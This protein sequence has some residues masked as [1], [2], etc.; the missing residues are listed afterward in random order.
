M[1][2]GRDAK[3]GGG[4]EPCG[5]VMGT[6]TRSQLS[7]LHALYWTR[8]KRLGRGI[9]VARRRSQHR[10]PSIKHFNSGGGRSAAKSRVLNMAV[11]CERQAY[12]GGKG[13]LTWETVNRLHFAPGG[14][15]LACRRARPACVVG[16]SGR[17]RL[18][19]CVHT[20]C[21]C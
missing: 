8:R 10:S 19:N 2:K 5:I 18:D 20:R 3:D 14:W 7:E 15:P 6:T 16:E 1:H 11:F 13:R 9:A 4:Q 17:V 12:G 21:S